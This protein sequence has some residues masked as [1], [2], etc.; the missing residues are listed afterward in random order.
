MW[1]MPG[2]AGTPRARALAAALREARRSSGFG[3][4]ELARK[5]SISHTQISHW[6]RGERVPNVENVAMML[7]ALRVSKGDR[8]N[9]LELARKTGEP[10]WLTA[11][12]SGIS[13]QLAGA[14]ECE[15]AAH[16]ITEWAPMIIPGLLQ[17]PDYARA[18]ARA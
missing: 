10:N 1:S 18:I 4:R 14:I 13:A 11:G 3:L 5:L 12:A 9:I 17:T 15:R 7:G 2:I 6:E 16:T 8:N